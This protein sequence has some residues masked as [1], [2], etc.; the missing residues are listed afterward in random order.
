MVVTSVYV[1]LA[2]VN[3]EGRVLSEPKGTG[4]RGKLSVVRTDASKLATEGFLE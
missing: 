2:M 1:R 4:A 3:V